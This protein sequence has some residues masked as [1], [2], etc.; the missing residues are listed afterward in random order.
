[1]W[2]GFTQAPLQQGYSLGW[3]L[4]DTTRPT[5]SCALLKA[6]PSAAIEQ[7]QGR[8]GGGAW[9]GCAGG[10]TAPASACEHHH[11][12]PAGA[13]AAFSFFGF[14]FLACCCLGAAGAGAAAGA[15]AAGLAAVG[16]AA[17]AAG[18]AAPLLMSAPLCRAAISSSI[19]AMA[20]FSWLGDAAIEACRQSRVGTTW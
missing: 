2:P 19:L 9:V 14:S 7:Q 1:M 18:R 12:A 10:N 3:S 15:A 13:G 20:A 6:S 4:T 17:A 11:S 8:V 16:A 5:A